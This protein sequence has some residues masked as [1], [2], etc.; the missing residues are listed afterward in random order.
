M[1]TVDLMPGVAKVIA[2]SVGHSDE[3]LDGVNVL[4]LHFWDARA[5]RQQGEP[6]QGLH[7]RVP[8][9]LLQ[10]QTDQAVCQNTAL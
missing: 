9:Q 2:I 6:R 3:G 10:R 8:L 5:G 4:L 7:I 1:R